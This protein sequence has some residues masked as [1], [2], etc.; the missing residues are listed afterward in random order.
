M[1][2]NCRITEEV[3]EVC[4]LSDRYYRV[5]QGWLRCINIVSIEVIETSEL[6][7]SFQEVLMRSCH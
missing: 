2:E 3:T 1:E 5:S 7:I 4:C 6:Q